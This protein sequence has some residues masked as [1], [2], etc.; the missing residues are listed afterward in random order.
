MQMAGDKQSSA[1]MTAVFDLKENQTIRR[2]ILTP[3]ASAGSLREARRQDSV[4][5]FKR[6]P[7]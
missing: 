7:S 2:E 6:E 1:G 4:S 5:E 3:L